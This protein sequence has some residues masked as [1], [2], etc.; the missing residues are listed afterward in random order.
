MN[1][2]EQ[3]GW[4]GLVVGAL[5]GAIVTGIIAHFAAP[6]P[7]LTPPQVIERVVSVEV[8]VPVIE[9]VEVP[10]TKH[11]ACREDEVGVYV[12]DDPPFYITHCIP[13]DD[14][15]EDEQGHMHWYTEDARGPRSTS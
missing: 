5:L 9:R 12:T 10:V 15:W 1:R 6:E 7:V 14:M 8:P 4:T 3:A 13:L 2:I 11:I